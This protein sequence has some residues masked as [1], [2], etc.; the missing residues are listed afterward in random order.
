M[1]LAMGG[2]VGCRTREPRNCIPRQCD[3]QSYWY[4]QA[5]HGV[6]LAGGVGGVHGGRYD[7]GKSL[8]GQV[9]FQTTDMR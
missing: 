1:G 3:A 4:R 7:L 5:I 8:D 6:R 2:M 9:S